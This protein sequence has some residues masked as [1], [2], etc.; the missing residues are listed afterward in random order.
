MS[1]NTYYNILYVHILNWDQN[2]FARVTSE[3][4]NNFQGYISAK[5]IMMT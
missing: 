4:K 5:L 2:N 3:P 1:P